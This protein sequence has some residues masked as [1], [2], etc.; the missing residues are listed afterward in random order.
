ML[1]GEAGYCNVAPKAESEVPIRAAHL[2]VA[3]SGMGGCVMQ[4][5]GSLCMP[6][7]PED[8]LLSHSVILYQQA[9]AM[10]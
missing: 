5:T 6:G 8:H 10:K 1:R 7:A 3:G 2:R 9:L 4:T